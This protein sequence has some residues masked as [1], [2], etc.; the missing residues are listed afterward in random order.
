MAASRA[1]RRQRIGSDIGRG[2]ATMTT[3]DAVLPD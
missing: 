2:F 3:T 1:T